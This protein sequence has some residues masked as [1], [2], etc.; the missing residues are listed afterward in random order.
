MGDRKL[1]GMATIIAKR[2][3]AQNW[4]SSQIPQLAR[5]KAGMDWA[6]K[7]EE[8]VYVARGCP[9]KHTKIWGKW[10]AHFGLDSQ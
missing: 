10:W 4:M 7:I 8:H 9:G 3:I 1:V 6:S 2:D 5:W